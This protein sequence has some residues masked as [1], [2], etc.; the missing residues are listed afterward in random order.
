MQVNLKKIKKLLRNTDSGRKNTF[1][2]YSIKYIE[3]VV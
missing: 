2:S 1:K 3:V